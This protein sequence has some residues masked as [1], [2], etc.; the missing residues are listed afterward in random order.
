MKKFLILIVLLFSFS[1]HAIGYKKF[2]P[3]VGI[4]GGLNVV[5]YS[6]ETNLKDIYYSATLNAG[7]RIGRKFGAELF[8]THSSANELMHTS[9]FFVVNHEVYYIGYGADFYGYYNISREFDFFMTLGIANYKTY[10]TYE[11][12]DPSESFADE[13]SVNN[14]CARIGVG[15][16]YTFLVDGVS[17]LARFQYIPTNN[18]LIKTMSEFSVGMRYIF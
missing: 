4:N 1:A 14:V 17:A 10:N 16:M 8:F 9:D 5:N 6:F 7:A 18:E 2:A 3:Y 15:V 12:I 11:Y 13:I